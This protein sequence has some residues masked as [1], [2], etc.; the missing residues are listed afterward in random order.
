MFFSLLSEI[1]TRKKF[2]GFTI[3]LPNHEIWFPRIS[4]F[5]A[6]REISFREF[7]KFFDQTRNLFPRNSNFE[8]L[9]IL[10][11]R[12]PTECDNSLMKVKKSNKLRLNSLLLSWNRFMRTGLLISKINHI[13]GEQVISSGWSAAG[14]PNALKNGETCL[15]PLDPFADIDPLVSEPSV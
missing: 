9:E 13:W 6:N 1:F 12:I 14:I 7:L 3:F 2:C 11:N 15:K 10:M 8:N 4:R 5:F